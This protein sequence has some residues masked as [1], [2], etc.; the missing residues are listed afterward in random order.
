MKQ[1]LSDP[2]FGNQLESNQGLDLQWVEGIPQL[3]AIP[4]DSIGELIVLFI[5]I[6]INLVIVGGI[7]YY[8]LRL[9]GKRKQ[10]AS[11]KSVSKITSEQLL[12]EMDEFAQKGDFQLAIKKCFHYLLRVLSEKRNIT[13]AKTKTNGEYRRDFM[14]VNRD[15]AEIFHKL[16]VYFDEVWYGEKEIGEQDY[17]QYR[18]SVFQFVGEVDL[19]EKR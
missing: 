19:H 12:T 8:V 5:I 13:F 3:S 14:R 2:E 9:Q 17:L 10:S 6:G 1:I 18:Q 11:E 16:S 15:E 4:I 7:A